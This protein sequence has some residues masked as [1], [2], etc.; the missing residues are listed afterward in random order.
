MVRRVSL[1]FWEFVM[2]LKEFI[3]KFEYIVEY[4]PL[5]KDFPDQT[6]KDEIFKYGDW[7]FTPEGHLPSHDFNKDVVKPGDTEYLDEEGNIAWPDGATTIRMDSDFWLCAVL[8]YEYRDLTIQELVAILWP[9]VE[10]PRFNPDTQ[11]TEAWAKI[12]D[13]V[14]KFYDEL[15]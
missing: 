13:N 6:Y 1:A 4:N 10:N 11:D 7:W 5:G 9:T 12:W 14:K 3:R 15:N 8:P 2:T